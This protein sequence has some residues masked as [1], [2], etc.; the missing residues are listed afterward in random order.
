MKYKKDS[1]LKKFKKKIK[2]ILSSKKITLFLRTHKNRSNIFEIVKRNYKSFIN[3][4]EIIQH[5]K[6]R[7]N[8]KKRSYKSIR[9]KI[10]N[11]F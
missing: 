3:K 1:R 8:D 2:S 5:K 7:S 9:N 11:E 6:R 10:I 4:R